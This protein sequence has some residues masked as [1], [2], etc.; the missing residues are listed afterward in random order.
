[1]P[2]FRQTA[3][4]GCGIIINRTAPQAQVTGGVTRAPDMESS[5]ETKELFARLMTRRD[6]LVL[7]GATGTLSCLSPISPVSADDNDAVLQARPGRPS[8]SV[9]PGEH[10]LGLSTDRDGLLYI[11]RGHD[12]NTSAPLA[13][14]LHGA[15]RNGQ[16]MEYTFSLADDF[17]VVIVAPDSRGRTWDA[18]LGEFG[19]DVAYIDAALRYTFARC[20]VD[21]TRLAIAGFSDG[22][23]YAL[24]LGTTN[25]DL[26]SHVIAF[27]PGFIA[28]AE[29]RGKP[30]I[31]ISH[32]KEDAVLPIDT[33]SRK[34]IR[35]LIQAGYN[36]KYREFIGPHTVPLRIAHEAFEWF[37]R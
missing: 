35:Q 15:D 24:S 29:L 34:I 3:N 2:I 6:F 20:A 37:M 28:P 1:M 7:A 26:F 31:F 11:P 25:G 14:M 23:S 5:N 16:A 22:A 18:I 4:R 21:P 27:S 17:G 8:T 33:T 32:G 10:K 13:V 19:A 9:T 30:R 12:V 36:L